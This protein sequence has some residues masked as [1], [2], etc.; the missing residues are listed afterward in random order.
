VRR[1]V[2]RQV[3]R[4]VGRKWN[5]KCIDMWN[6]V[7]NDSTSGSTSGMIIVKRDRSGMTS[8]TANVMMSATTSAGTCE[9]T[10]VTAS[11]TTSATIIK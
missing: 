1:H 2:K 4:K 8:A 10:S 7:G 5:V 9:T 11:E 6:V 3:K